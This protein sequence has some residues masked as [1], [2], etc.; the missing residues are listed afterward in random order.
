MDYLIFDKQIGEAISRPRPFR[1]D[2]QL[3]EHQVVLQYIKDDGVVPDYDV[4]THRLVHSGPRYCVPDL[5]AGTCTGQYQ[6]VPLTPEQ[7]GKNTG[8][9]RA[10][11]RKRAIRNAYRELRDMD[12]EDI[13][14]LETAR[15]RIVKMAH[16]MAQ[17]IQDQ[18]APD[19]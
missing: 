17:M 12:E 10:S 3:T 16:T 19:E 15:V 8:K 5:E 6:V 18:Y 4:E 14:D 9:R 7:K 2:V 13:T 11:L 1:P